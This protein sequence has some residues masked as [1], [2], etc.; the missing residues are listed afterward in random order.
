VKTK[1]SVVIATRN[2]S[3]TILNAINSVEM[4]ESGFVEI[5]VIDCCSTDGTLEILKSFSNKVSFLLSEPDSGIYDAWNKGVAAAKG[6]WVA[7]L[8]ADD[9]YY[10][11][12]MAEYLNCLS[13]AEQMNIDYI[14]SRACLLKDG[15]PVRVIGQPW[16][17]PLFGSR[18]TVAHVGSLHSKKLLQ[19][20]G[21]F[22]TS[23]RICGDYEFL[24]RPQGT[25]NALYLPITTV[26]M[27]V[28]GVSNSNIK[29]FE[30]MERAKV[31]SGGRNKYIARIERL[32]G[33]I[34]WFFR[35]K[36]W[37]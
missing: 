22:D 18:M 13:K 1:I 26:G 6:D 32:I 29:V 33:M 37:Y 7:F 15:I 5:V 17:W 28:G 21:K 24:L 3:K 4:I 30:E 25:L 34:K 11:G 16:R 2:C 27:S 9:F 36:L 23:Y 20:F 35:R 14:S 10:P 19:R 8:G 12:S 31:L